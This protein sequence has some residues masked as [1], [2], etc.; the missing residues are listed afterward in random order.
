[1]IGIAMHADDSTL[2]R[3]L[4][5]AAAVLAAL[6]AFAAI[7][8]QTG[9]VAPQASAAVSAPRGVVVRITEKAVDYAKV[10]YA[11]PI[12]RDIADVLA[13]HFGGNPTAAEIDSR[14]S[15]AQL[16][17]AA[18]IAK[19]GKTG[20]TSAGEHPL[21]VLLVRV[22]TL[23]DRGEKINCSAVQRV[24]REDWPTFWRSHQGDW[25][26]PNGQPLKKFETVAVEPFAAPP[27]GKAAGDGPQ[28]PVQIVPTSARTVP[29][30]A[31]SPLWSPNAAAGCDCNGNCPGC[32][33]ASR[34]TSAAPVYLTPV[35]RGMVR[36]CRNCG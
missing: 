4:R 36:G 15:E 20:A 3:G 31:A 24:R 12:G 28:W 29:L 16:R 21:D 17:D 33:C 8:L 26:Y 32:T 35:R 7:I 9:C 14:L 19:E 13:K 30:P 6:A 2:L 11:D 10:K 34:A 18:A 1:M 22:C 5:R 27:G 25:K 23:N